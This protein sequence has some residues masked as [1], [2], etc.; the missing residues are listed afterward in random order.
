[1][2]SCLLLG[3]SFDRQLDIELWTYRTNG[4]LDYV[5]AFP[6]LP[7]EKMAQWND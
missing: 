5:V 7:S 3:Q 2:E 6:D 4:E 1:M